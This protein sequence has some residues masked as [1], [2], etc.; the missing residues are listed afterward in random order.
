MKLLPHRRLA[1][2]RRLLILLCLALS[3]VLAYYLLSAPAADKAAFVYKETAADKEPTKMLTTV[4]A[5]PQ[6]VAAV[7]QSAVKVTDIDCLIEDTEQV[8]CIRRG[9]D[10]YVPFDYLKRRYELS[11]GLSEDGRQLHWYASY[12]RLHR[13]SL[14]YSPYGAFLH[15]ADYTV[16]RRERVLRV[17]G[18]R[19]VPISRQ[20]DPRGHEYVIQVA[21]Y[22]LS[23][24]SKASIETETRRRENSNGNNNNNDSDEDSDEFAAT[25]SFGEAATDWTVPDGAQ[26]TEL[27]GN[28]TARV[29][30]PPPPAAQQQRHSTASLLRFNVP[31]DLSRG[32][33]LKLARDSPT[34]SG[35]TVLRLVDF[36]S[37][38][39]ASVTVQMT[40]NR[41]GT[42]RLHYG[43]GYAEDYRAPGDRS[44]IYFAIGSPGDGWRTVT[45]NLRVDLEKAFEDDDDD[46]EEVAAVGSVDI[47]AAD[48]DESVAGVED[49]Q[50]RNR[51]SRGRGRGRGRS[52]RGT[53]RR[54]GR[55]RRRQ[56]NNEGDGGG[57]NRNRPVAIRRVQWISLRGVGYL[58]RVEFAT[59]AAARPD[60][61]RAAG[62]WLVANQNAST[63]AWPIWARRAIGSRR[64][65]RRLVLQPG[66]CSAMGQG[67]AI[68]LLVRLHRHWPDRSDYLA[69]AVR[70]LAPFHRDAASD[71]T[72][73]VAARLFNQFTWYE[74]YPVPGGLFVL[75]GFV[76]S[77]FG[78][79]DLRQLLTDL[80]AKQ[81]GSSS[82]SS[83]QLIDGASLHSHL[84]NVS[85]LYS[86]G[87]ESLKSVIGLFD[88]GDGTYYDLRH[89]TNPTEEPRRARWDYHGVH[90]TQLM[91]LTTLEPDP[92]LLAALDRWEKYL[93]GYRVSHN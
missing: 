8:A 50:R 68:S 30:P 1:S 44:D 69:A 25:R 39:A 20:W 93:N 31:A 84:A 87:M 49:R 4:L 83:Q 74:E 27:T 82:S 90:V 58:G 28:A 91:A 34:S 76:Y 79:Y 53:R 23:H 66:W 64:D 77:L 22:G 10:V 11:G 67:Q 42:V 57:G 48:E 52:R 15:F 3:I 65:R 12:A 63:G 80:T 45:R 24:F 72:A 62:D 41:R 16:E 43:V 70:G 7:P 88:H 86:T 40:T 89:V 33:R 9:A 5:R 51:K 2:P 32:A 35:R 26:L 46:S 85:R 36:L 55:G 29:S 14:P 75:N 56:R 38:S 17:S 59:A 47:G 54:P 37:V 71:S 18:R 6:P 73:G 21:Q 78:L 19:G 61:Y 81:N 92:R 13:P 60:F